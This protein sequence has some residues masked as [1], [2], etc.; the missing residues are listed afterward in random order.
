M[1]ARVVRELSALAVVVPEDVLYLPTLTIDQDLTNRQLG[2][3][4]AV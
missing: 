2:A 4:V 1:I 3:L